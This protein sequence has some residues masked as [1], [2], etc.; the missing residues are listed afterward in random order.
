MVKTL[1]FHY[2]A[3]VQSMVGKLRIFKLCGTAKQ[4]NKQQ[5]PLPLKK[6]HTHTNKRKGSNN[7]CPLCFFHFTKESLRVINT[8]TSLVHLLENGPVSCFT[9]THPRKYSVEWNKGNECI[10]F[11]FTWLTFHIDTADE[12]DGSNN[13]SVTLHHVTANINHHNLQGASKKW[14]FL[15]SALVF[16]LHLLK[17][18]T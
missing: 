16:G 9:S 17:I 8:W 10:L 11:P 2:Q 1:W 4:T 7:F 13:F 3:R 18:I 5:T 14:H 15:N 6:N 12:Q